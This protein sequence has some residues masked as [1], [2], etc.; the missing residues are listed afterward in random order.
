MFY[1]S[2]THSHSIGTTAAPFA[3]GTFEV[4]IQKSVKKQGG[5]NQP[6]IKG[7]RTDCAKAGELIEGIDTQ[8]VGGS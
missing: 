6:V 1:T 3:G 5:A 4:G 8:P 2:L 7:V